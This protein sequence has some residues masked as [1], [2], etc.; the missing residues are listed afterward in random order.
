VIVKATTLNPRNIPQRR[1]TILKNNG[2]TGAAAAAYDF[3]RHAS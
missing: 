3:R 2:K 1:Q